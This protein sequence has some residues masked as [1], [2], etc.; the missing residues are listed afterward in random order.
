MSASSIVVLGSTNWDICMYLPHL[1]M[2]GETV[3]SGRMQ[4]NLGGKGANQAVAC[5]KAGGNTQFISCIGNDATGQNILQMFNDLALPTDSIKVVE[6]ST[7]TA[8]IFIDSNA[9][10]CIGLTPGANKWLNTEVV[11]QHY[12]DIANANV[13]LMQLETPPATIFHAATIAKQ[14]NTKVILNPA[15]AARLNDDVFPLVDL[16]TPNRGELAQ[17]AGIA[18]DS[19]DGLVK[20]CSVL[21]EKGVKA[22]VVTLGRDGAFLYTPNTQQYFDAFPVMAIDTTAAGDTFNGY[23]TASLSQ[24]WDFQLSIPTASAAAALSVK[25]R[26]AIPSIPERSAVSE[27]M[28]EQ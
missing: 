27:F 19:D 26:G 16:L 28:D 8:C 6:D 23:L 11:D 17:L 9:E 22:L 7:G 14:K 2:P 10:N 21:I 4:T 13:L 15:P 3:G 20:A 25:K 5:H 24:A 18:T 12:D 1:P